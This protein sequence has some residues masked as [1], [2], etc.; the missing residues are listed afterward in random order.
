M[1]KKFEKSFFLVPQPFWIAA[2]NESV[3]LT[4]EE[5]RNILERTIQWAIV[6]IHMKRQRVLKL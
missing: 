2:R 3:D 5:A 1:T 6:N 4:G